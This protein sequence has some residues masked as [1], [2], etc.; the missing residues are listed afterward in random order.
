MKA[1]SLTPA[2]L[3][4]NSKFC[5][6]GIAIGLS[7]LHLLLTWRVVGNID[8]LI[9]SALFW[10]AILCLLWRKQD[11]INLESGIFSSFF[12]LLLMALV[13]VKS[14]SLFWFESSFLK[15]LPL[16]AALGLGLLASGTKG[17]KQYWRELLLVLLLCIPESFLVQII[18]KLFNI[19]TL[20]AQFAVF[21]LWYL[22]F[23]VT[24][25]GASVILPHDSVWVAPHCTGI[26]TALLLLK[27][28]VV[29]IL[30]SPTDWS[31][32]VLVSV[33]S[34]FMTFVVSG[35]RVALIASVVSNQE[36]FNY[37]HG[38]EGNQ[39]FSTISILLFGLLCHFLL[40]PDKLLTPD[41]KLQ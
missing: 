20:T 6:F 15:I 22:G 4:Q 18:D 27:L 26:S 23:E 40:Q 16:I 25:Q 41:V 35:I 9:I 3:L 10:G 14:I 30:M 38:A 33:S 21:I 13:L 36:A 11:N 39:I 31:K 29:L 34:V 2:S 32:K 5:L 7:M 8:R 19:T 1:F 17:L 12:G 28:S 37:W 24:R